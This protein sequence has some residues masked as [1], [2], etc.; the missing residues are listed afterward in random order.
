MTDA[1]TLRKQADAAAKACRYG[2]ARK[3]YLLAFEAD[4]TD[5]DAAVAAASMALELGNIL[6]AIEELEELVARGWSR[7][8]P[9]L[10]RAQE[11]ARW[12]AKKMESDQVAR[13]LI[14]DREAQRLQKEAAAAALAASKAAASK[15]AAAKAVPSVRAPAKA[16]GHAQ[17][18][19]APTL[20]DNPSPTLPAITPPAV[21]AAP[22]PRHRVL[23]SVA[24]FLLVALAGAWSRGPALRALGVD[25]EA[26]PDAER[27]QHER[28]SYLLHGRSSGGPTGLPSFLAAP[29]LPGFL[30]DPGVP[31][32]ALPGF[33]ANP[34]LPWFLAVPGPSG[35][36]AQTAA[37]KKGAAEPKARS[38][39]AAAPPAPPARRIPKPAELQAGWAKLASGNVTLDEVSSSA[40]EVTIRFCE[41]QLQPSNQA[42]GTG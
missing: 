42:A 37:A 38:A 2:E 8:Q 20:T 24:L 28:N 32:P 19:R 31:K 36:K 18:A 11:A 26:P 29:G 16:A 39:A 6:P 10:E 40:S 35:H 5:V 23:L 7:A 9:E 13:Q 1:A 34:G 4:S 15:T 22:P 17:P 41:K 27:V 33:L 14:A 12:Q 30:A 3:K 21:T 25:P